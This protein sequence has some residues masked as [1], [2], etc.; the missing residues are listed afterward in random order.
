MP[1]LRFNSVRDVFVGRGTRHDPFC[2]SAYMSLQ[3][4]L[5]EPVQYKAD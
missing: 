4:K 1:R 3:F 5:I 2:F